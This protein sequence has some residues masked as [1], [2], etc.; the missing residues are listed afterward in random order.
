MRIAIEN[1]QFIG[2]GFY[3]DYGNKIVWQAKSALSIVWRDGQYIT[4]AENIDEA[5]AEI[6]RILDV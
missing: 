6:K 5:I 4:H 1:L 3:Y 2:N